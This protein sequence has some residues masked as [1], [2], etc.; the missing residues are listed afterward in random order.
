MTGS[1]AGSSVA[2]HT[3]NRRVAIG[4]DDRPL[5][6]RQNGGLRVA[7]AGRQIGDRAA[8]FPLGDS[9]WVDAVALSQRP[10]ALLTMLYRSGPYGHARDR[11]HRP[12]AA[13]PMRTISSRLSARRRLPRSRT[14][15]GRLVVFP[16]GHRLALAPP[17]A[18]DACRF[19]PPRVV[20]ACGK[21][22]G[23]CPP[24][25]TFPSAADRILF[26]KMAHSMLPSNAARLSA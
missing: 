21:V 1:D 23:L 3:G 5:L 16:D 24:Q 26:W 10:Q 2:A 11:P 4:G 14:C 12:K 7:R 20:A 18:G 9:L 22:D 6:D 19:D 13:D 8:P 17:V 15:R 25:R